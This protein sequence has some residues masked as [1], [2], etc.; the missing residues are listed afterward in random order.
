MAGLDAAADGDA[1]EQLIQPD[2][3]QRIFHLQGG[4]VSGMLY[5]MRWLRSG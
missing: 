4:M 5:I 1:P 2:P 3:R